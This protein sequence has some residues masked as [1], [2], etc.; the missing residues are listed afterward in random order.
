MASDDAVVALLLLHLVAAAQFVIVDGDGGHEHVYNG[1][2]TGSMLI[3]IP[4]TS[5]LPY[6]C[7]PHY[8]RPTEA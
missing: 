6:S 2:Y 7:R 5:Q 3:S 8:Y 4:I 1:A